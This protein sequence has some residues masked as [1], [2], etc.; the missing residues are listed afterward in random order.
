M[1]KKCY[2]HAPINLLH[3]SSSNKDKLPPIKFA[4]RSASPSKFIS[5]NQKVGLSIIQPLAMPFISP[6]PPVLLTSHPQNSPLISEFY[7][8]PE[9]PLIFDSIHNPKVTTTKELILET[10]K[11][12]IWLRPKEIFHS[13]YCLFGKKIGPE[14]VHQGILADCYFL[15]C[16]CSLA[17]WPDRIKKLFKSLKKTENGQ[18]F[19]YGFINGIKK[20]FEIDDNFLCGQIC[21]IPVFAQPNDRDIWVLLLEK[22]WA[23]INK[24][25]T[26]I[27]YGLETE[28]FLFLTGAPPDLYVHN[29]MG[30][31]HEEL[32]FILFDAYTKGFPI[33][34]STKKDQPEKEFSDAGLM[35]Y[36]VYSI[37]QILEINEDE[38]VRILVIRDQLHKSN[39]TGNYAR[40]RPEWTKIEKKVR[41]NDSACFS[42]TF[43]DY[44]KYFKE[45]VICK[46]HDDY[47]HNIVEISNEKFSCYFMNLTTDFD[48]YIMLQQYSKRMQKLRSENYEFSPAFIIIGKIYED[49]SVQYIKSFNL[50]YQYQH[51][52][53]SLTP[54][55]YAI[56]TGAEWANNSPK[57]YTF[58]FYGNTQIKFQ[59]SDWYNELFVSI[60]VDFVES[61]KINWTHIINDFY[62][63]DCIK[64]EYGFGVIYLKYDPKNTTEKYKAVYTEKMNLSG[65][66]RIYPSGKGDISVTL[67]NGQ[68]L[69]VIYYFTTTGQYKYS[70]TYNVNFVNEA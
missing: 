68:F 21:K 47:C 6:C 22:L 61:T 63:Y 56:F 40:T 49:A 26:N 64:A 30:I 58:C 29:E 23:K 27:E 67:K 70:Y 31:T 1:R 43:E 41:Y 15:A 20:T 16:I 17:K 5:H 69:P 51:Y 54:G 38:N 62:I 45:T 57:N 36:H 44:L 2:S 9:F 52:E 59:K 50:I 46:Y 10:C 24:C 55:R 28:S 11:R 18:Y 34:G 33:T 39:W 53:I 35:Q 66:E 48:G 14:V 3:R 7:E 4:Y 65:L 19:L 13:D 8:D 32:W 42:I 60:I 37:L 12:V 25:F